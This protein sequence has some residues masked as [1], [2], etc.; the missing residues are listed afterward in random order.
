MRVVVP[1]HR[2]S[3]DA[4]PDA[5]ASS[6]APK[7]KAATQSQPAFAS[8]SPSIPS[9]TRCPSSCGVA[10]IAARAAIDPTKR[11]RWRFLSWRCEYIF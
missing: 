11:A 6:E 2:V 1:P 4:H 3:A 9:A 5:E 8:P 10:A 7:A